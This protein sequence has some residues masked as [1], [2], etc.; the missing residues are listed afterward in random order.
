MTLLDTCMPG[1]D[2]EEVLRDSQ[3][4]SN[5]KCGD[6]DASADSESMETEAK[7]L[8]ARDFLSKQLSLD[9]LIAAVCPG[10]QTSEATNSQ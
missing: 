2:G 1:L 10:A 6:V 9:V 3:R 5:G 4:G 8:G 7:R